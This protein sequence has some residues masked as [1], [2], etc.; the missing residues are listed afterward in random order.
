M[1]ITTLGSCRQHSIIK[2]YNLTSIQETISYPHYSKEVLQL[3][4]FCKY[5]NLTPEETTISFRTPIINHEPYIFNSHLCD[6]FN[7]SDVYVIE[8]ASKIKY[9]YKHLYLHHIATNA[10]YNVPIR[11]EIVE[12]IQTKNEIE[13]DILEMKYL[14][15]EKIIIVC[16]LVTRDNGE[17]YILK[18]WLEDICNRHHILFIDPVN[19]LMKKYNTL[20]GF[21]EPEAVLAH[22]TPAGHNAIGEIYKEFISKI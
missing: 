21:F 14:L 20:N 15:G 4:K 22:Y 1:K 6:E 3:I 8:I 18:C 7:T 12:S 19:E 2:H 17:R 13:T 11:N 9:Q 16:H 5:G 10:E